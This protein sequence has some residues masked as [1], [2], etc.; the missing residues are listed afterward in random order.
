MKISDICKYKK[1]GLIT[2]FVSIVSSYASFNSYS[3]KLVFLVHIV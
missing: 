3:F 1:I 2:H